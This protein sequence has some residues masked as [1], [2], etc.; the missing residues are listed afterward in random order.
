MGLGKRTIVIS[1]FE[2]CETEIV[3]CI[4][5]AWL[6]LDYELEIGDSQFVFSLG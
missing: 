3:M 1:G 4:S 5:V 6:F 2:V